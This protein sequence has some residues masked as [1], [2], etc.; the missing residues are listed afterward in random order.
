MLNPGEW[1]SLQLLR[2]LLNSTLPFVNK[3]RIP[4]QKSLRT[5][6]LKQHGLDLVQMQV[7]FK[8]GLVQDM[9]IMEENAFFFLQYILLFWWNASFQCLRF[10][11]V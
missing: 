3:G 5:K 9:E 8:T 2:K 7:S 6:D 4:F 11:S 1:I 10:R